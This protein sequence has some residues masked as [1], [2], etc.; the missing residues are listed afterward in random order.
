MEPVW[1]EAA[2]IPNSRVSAY[3]FFASL[4]WNL[5]SSSLVNQATY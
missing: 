2:V 5:I 3:L 4:A 1:V